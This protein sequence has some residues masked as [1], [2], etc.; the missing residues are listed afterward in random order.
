M[1]RATIAASSAARDENSFYKALKDLLL[2][3][4]DRPVKQNIVA[5][6]RANWRTGRMIRELKELKSFDEFVS[7]EEQLRHVLVSQEARS[8]TKFLNALLIEQF[9]AEEQLILFEEE[10]RER[11]VLWH[12]SVSALERDAMRLQI[13]GDEMC[14]RFRITVEFL[15]GL[16]CYRLE[17]M[18]GRLCMEQMECRRQL[19]ELEEVF[20][21]EINQR[22]F[23]EACRHIDME[24]VRQQAYRVCMWGRLA[25]DE[26][27]HNVA[28]LS[29][30]EERERCSLERLYALRL[31]V[32]ANEE[33]NN[34]ARL[35]VNSVIRASMMRRKLE[36]DSRL[37]EISAILLRLPSKEEELRGV[38]ERYEMEKRQELRVGFFLLW[39]ETYK[40]ELPLSEATTVVGRL[41]VYERLC[42]FDQWKHGLNAIEDCY[43]REKG[44]VLE[45]EAACDEFFRDVGSAFSKLWKDENEQF[46]DLQKKY[47]QFVWSTRMIKFHVLLSSE[48]SCERRQLVEEEAAACMKLKFSMH[49]AF[50]E[51]MAVLGMGGIV[52]SEKECWNS[53]LRWHV[54]YV[55]RAHEMQLVL[56]EAEAR[57]AILPEVR[58]D[59]T[60]IVMQEDALR[61]ISERGVEHQGCWSEPDTS[62]G[63]KPA[64][65]EMKLK[66]VNVEE[67][68]QRDVL[69]RS[70][71]DNRFM[72]YAYILNDVEDCNR[73]GVVVE[74]QRHILGV[75][76]SELVEREQL[77]R[78][79][80][81]RGELERRRAVF[82][83][84]LHEPRICVCK[85]DELDKRLDIIAEAEVAVGAIC[86]A[87]GKRCVVRYGTEELWSAQCAT[88]YRSL[89]EI[90]ALQ[91]AELVRVVE[92]L[93]RTHLLFD[94]RVEHLQQM[95]LM[96][97]G[98]RRIL[99][100]EKAVAAFN[101]LQDIFDRIISREDEW[102]NRTRELHP[103]EVLTGAEAFIDYLHQCDAMRS[104]RLDAQRIRIRKALSALLEE[105]YWDREHIV[106]EEH[107][108]RDT[109]F[110]SLHQPHLALVNQ[111]S[112][113]AEKVCIRLYN[114]AM[115]TP[116]AME[117][118]SLTMF[119]AESTAAVSCALNEVQTFSAAGKVFHIQFPESELLLT[120]SLADSQ[121]A[122]YFCVSE[123]STCSVVATATLLLTSE[124]LRLATNGTVLPVAL[125]QNMG[126][127]NLVLHAL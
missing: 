43:V 76:C 3:A 73:I 68:A 119:T 54:E 19:Y 67:G 6:P 106:L 1:L 63:R 122:L 7:M 30:E 94:E 23:L 96:E 5:H 93:F 125:D 84:S 4:P 82:G 110:S 8:R 65:F 42:I 2:D 81:L 89:G 116:T 46:N 114:V 101:D 58:G 38:I 29:A 70:E 97:E 61:S 34:A 124:E 121:T 39:R 112:V 60:G 57:C 79:V 123:T 109:L 17:H 104:V 126:K 87:F 21:T 62:Q 45:L 83:R 59:W 50:L 99:I 90:L 48:E 24:L 111:P 14:A 92:P 26:F 91:A 56:D 20:R 120:L 53:L 44:R 127:M 13:V 69:V 41:E 51:H 77:E 95:L 47:H 16:R 80:L 9:L 103:V 31:S 117:P 32:L 12:L 102:R 49:F 28:V 15:M 74:C 11:S 71:L 100:E 55:R 10:R 115:T 37:R 118:L 72:E 66:T 105:F 113:P 86:Y 40:R 85:V 33:E 108:G 88:H 64:Y 107:V 78:T 35:I 75:L 25:C 22:K 18:A 98:R 52:E 27:S 36:D